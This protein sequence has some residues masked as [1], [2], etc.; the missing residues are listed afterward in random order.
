MYIYMYKYIYIYTLIYMHIRDLLTLQSSPDQA[1]CAAPCC[2]ASAF[3]TRF[4]NT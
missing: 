4:P 2:G 3:A 1:H